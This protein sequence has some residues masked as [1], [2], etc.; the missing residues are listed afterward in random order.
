MSRKEKLNT[1][2]NVQKFYTLKSKV[3]NKTEVQINTKTICSNKSD[4]KSIYIEKLTKAFDY[5]GKTRKVKV[6]G[7]NV[8]K[9]LLF[10]NSLADKIDEVRVIKKSGSFDLGKE[11]TAENLEQMDDR[12]KLKRRILLYILGS[13][14]F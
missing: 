9:T 13:F 5:N 14:G 2:A 1:L 10:G 4:T 7:Q 6:L 8:E 3:C 12:N 11:K